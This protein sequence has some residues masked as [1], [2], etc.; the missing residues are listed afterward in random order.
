MSTSNYPDPPENL[1]D[2]VARAKASPVSFEVPHP[3]EINEMEIGD[4]MKI[5][6]TRPDGRGERFWVKLVAIVRVGPNKTFTGA[7]ANDLTIFPEYP[8]GSLISFHPCHVLGI[9]RDR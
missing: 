6:L 7:V 5:G 4:Y 9:L 2:G 8:D 1:I 3:M